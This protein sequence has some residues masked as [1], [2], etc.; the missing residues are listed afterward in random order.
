M[1]SSQ[2]TICTLCFE[3]FKN[4]V[5]L[6]CGHNLCEPCLK[7][8]EALYKALQTLE[9]P[10]K[11]QKTGNK[12]SSEPCIAC[13]LCG[14][15]TPV[16][17]CRPNITL[18]NVLSLRKNAAVLELSKDGSGS[19]GSSG[20]LDKSVC[21]FCKGPATVYCAFC[22]PLC[23]E[24]SDFL[25]VKGPL[26][27]HELSTTPLNVV[28]SIKQAFAEANGGATSVSTTVLPL[29]KDHGKQMELFCSK[30]ETLVCSHCILIGDHKGHECSN[31]TQAFKKTNERID[32]LLAKIK[33]MAPECET[34]V[35]SYERLRSG[36]ESEHEQARATVKEAFRQFRE[37]VD[38][39]QASA[40]KEV[41]ELFKNFTETVESRTVSLHALSEECSL[42][43][44]SADSPAAKNELIRYTLFKSLKS[45]A[46]HL[47]VVSSA[48]V[49]DDATI[50]QVDV[51]KALMKKDG[52]GLV[53]V[54]STF[55][56]GCGRVLFYNISF[57]GL[58]ATRSTG[59]EIATGNNT[60]HD[61]GAIYDPIRRI[62]LSVSGNFNNGRNVKITTM[63]DGTHGETALR[64]DVIPF[65][66]HGQYPI[67]DGSQY[68]YFLQSEDDGNNSIGRLDMD[69]MEFERL[70]SLP[71]SSFRE[72]CRGC[73]QNGNIYAL[74]RELNV[75]E[76]NTTERTW[77]TLRCSVPRPGCLM[78]DPAE[79]NIIYC[80]CTDGNGLFRI[81][82][83]EEERTHYHDT[84]SNFSLGANGEAVLVRV[85]PTE[86]L[87]FCGL[88]GGWHCYS[89]ER[90]RWINL[91]HW[92]NVRNGSGHLVI[93]PDGPTAF[94]H[95]DDSERWDMVPLGH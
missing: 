54:R 55:R 24:H 69:T 52:L 34:L 92:R 85:S 65:G 51:N 16:K 63:T 29:C 27:S 11:N 7:R 56:L 12:D 19:L 82:I 14:K 40:E 25:H 41:E 9:P 26:H 94:Y 66:N 57:D 31:V 42:I 89:S 46:D 47:S 60:S 23:Q 64:T 76:F 87:I 32:E 5:I 83:A 72:F 67:F 20:E 88:S 10:K 38:E 15:V 79:P 18:R 37:L 33:E 49:P 70:P 13:P 6:N 53:K 86:F 61:G 36:A 90:E 4:P 8:A 3:T 39:S 28:K 62:I 75:R 68:T 71:T 2:D 74:D 73:F 21:G 91:H 43:Q 80:L 17:D 58:D 81:D 93:V 59:S 44:K 78:A 45:L 48:K 35:K 22:G 50:C 1:T 95:V 84:P 77:R 30:C